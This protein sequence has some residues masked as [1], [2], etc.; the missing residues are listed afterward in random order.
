MV[1][2]QEWSWSLR[3][4][5]VGLAPLSLHFPHHPAPRQWRP[6][7]GFGAASGNVIHTFVR[8][9]TTLRLALLILETVGKTV[10]PSSHFQRWSLD[11]GTAFV[12]LVAVIPG[13][14]CVL[15]HW[16]A[17]PAPHLSPFSLFLNIWGVC[18]WGGSQWVVL[19]SLYSPAFYVGGVIT[20]SYLPVQ[21]TWKLLNCHFP[22]FKNQYAVF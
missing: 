12:V 11:L 19:N 7:L 13:G 14:L 15:Y 16:A 20:L 8:H 21:G 9:D 1:C 5:R 6:F 17:P 4:L 18:V 10:V 22:P 2:W 3:E